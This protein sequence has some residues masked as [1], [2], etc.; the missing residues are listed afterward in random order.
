VSAGLAAR[1]GLYG[2][3]A[4]EAGPTISPFASGW[5]LQAHFLAG[6]PGRATRLMRSMWADFMLDDARMTDSSFV[7][8]YGVDG[9]LHYPAYAND[10]RLSHAHG[11]STGPVF[12]LTSL[13]AGVEVVGAEGWVFRPQTGDLTSV[14]AGFEVARG[15]YSFDFK[16]DG[17]RG[18]KYR[19]STPEGTSGSLVLDLAGCDADVKVQQMGKGKGFE[20][21]RWNTGIHERRTVG[22]GAWSRKGGIVTLEGLKGGDY[23]VDMTCG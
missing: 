3:P 6:Q 11:W 17:K 4:P 9:S 5:K 10:A 22:H 13:L 2:A 8:G 1:W 23:V 14:E 7:E 12:A 19:F 16:S 15:R 18:K 20:G 21:Y